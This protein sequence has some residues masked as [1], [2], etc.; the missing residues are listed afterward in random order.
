MSGINR[1]RQVNRQC[2]VSLISAVFLI[3]AIAVLAALMTK[4]LQLGTAKSIKEVGAVKVLAAADSA[5][6]AAAYDIIHNDNCLTRTDI[7][8]PVGDGSTAKY[9]AICLP[10]AQGNLYVISATGSN[11]SGANQSIRSFEVQF[12][13]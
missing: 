1:F 3:T 8:V 2:G 13:P 12:I 5:V 11:G 9:S 10:T 4:L 7:A 6:S